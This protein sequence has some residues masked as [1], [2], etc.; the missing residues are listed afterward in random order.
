ML[1]ITGGKWR[2][3]KI[4]ITPRTVTRYTPQ[5]A[6]KALF[7]IIDV[8]DM[9]FLDIFSG[10]GIVAFEALSREARSV[11]SIDSSRISYSTIKKNIETL[12]PDCS[13]FKV[14]L[15]DFR[16]AV[17]FL[18][19]KGISF[20]YIFADPPFYRGYA[21]VFLEV[22]QS[23][24]EILKNSGTLILESSEKESESIKNILDSNI[25]VI[26]DERNYGNVWFTFIKYK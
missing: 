26:T 25:F 17:P 8:F 18:V 9:S 3:R 16:R 21:D 20:D 19:S 1:S 5:M 15:K 4:D 7:D 6:R 12:S 22:F 11:L 14:I 2:K 23:S 13:N 24:K 10:S